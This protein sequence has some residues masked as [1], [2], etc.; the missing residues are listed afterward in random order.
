MT[1]FKSKLNRLNVMKYKEDR[2][3]TKIES[4]AELEKIIKA[5]ER[6]LQLL[7]NR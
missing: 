6:A 7:K 4:N 3:K 5:N 2:P 1:L